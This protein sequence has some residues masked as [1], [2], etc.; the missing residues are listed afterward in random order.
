MC[1]TVF[2]CYHSI[3]YRIYNHSS[4]AGV[5]SSDLITAIRRS[6]EI[7]AEIEN[8]RIGSLKILKI[9]LLGS[10]NFKILLKYSKKFLGGPESGK[11]T[12]FKQMK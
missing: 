5:N 3:N 12:I 9:L 1:S 6:E 10:N 11:S 2:C 8:E 7:D 4:I